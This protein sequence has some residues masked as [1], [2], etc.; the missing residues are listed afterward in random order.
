MRLFKTLLLAVKLRLRHETKLSLR[1]YVKGFDKI[2]IG[3]KSK[4]NDSASLDATRQGSISIGNGVTINR[5]AMIQADRGGVTLG[6]RV[7]INNF[8]IVNG[9]GGVEIGDDT[10]IG[11]G[12]KIISYQHKYS[13][14][15]KIRNQE[16]IGKPIVIGRDVW[17]GSNAVIMAGVTIGD[18]AVIGAGAVVN[19]DVPANAVMTGVPATVK[20]MR[21]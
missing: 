18:G 7:E 13:A 8:T 10:L 15:D 2:S 9:T 11:P 4:I 1:V 21:V 6:N 12:V 16:T 5:Y 17:I 14:V 19:R 20:K 3:R